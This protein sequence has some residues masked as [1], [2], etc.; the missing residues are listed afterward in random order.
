MPRAWR[1]TPPRGRIYWANINNNTISFANLDGSGAGGQ[2]S[3][4]G[5]TV[6]SP[7][8][9]AIDPAAGMIYWANIGDDTISFAKLDGSGGGGQLSTAGA[10]VNSPFSL[11]L[12]RAPNG[13]GA[14]VLAG[15]GEVGQELSC[16]QGSWAPDLLGSF[17]YRAPQN[18]DY[19]WQKDAAEIGG[20]TQATY[21][22][23]E[24]GEYSC[25]VTA[26]NHAGSASQTSAP[27]TVSA[28]PVTPSGGETPV[29][30]SGGE[31][32]GDPGP[33]DS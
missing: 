32:P 20:A 9:V 2:L 31:T 8:G 3:T 16:G 22:P 29:T 30:P 6:N 26:S 7:I 21:T 23:T 13:I 18:F 17:L 1:S 15:G 28:V 25:G 5:A 24:P 19:Q 11:A 12:L 10:T 33:T 27:R 4:A 14:P